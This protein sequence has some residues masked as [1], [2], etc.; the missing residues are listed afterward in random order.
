MLSSIERVQDVDGA[1]EPTSL[2]DLPLTRYQAFYQFC[3]DHLEPY[4]RDRT[5][6]VLRVVSF[7][8]VGGLGAVVN[9]VCVW[10]LSHFTPIPGDACIV[11]ATEIA[12][13][14][15]FLLNDRFT[16]HEMVD[17]RRP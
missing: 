9:L 15:N 8:I 7:L 11:L 16:F 17:G 13:L 10:A 4:T 3:Y 5:A 6:E 2:P 14:F 12:L 1:A